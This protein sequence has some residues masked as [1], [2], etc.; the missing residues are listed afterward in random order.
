MKRVTQIYLFMVGR[1]CNFIE[2]LGDQTNDKWSE[3]NELLHC[4]ALF[5]ESYLSNRNK[6]A[7]N[8]T[9]N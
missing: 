3:F 7:Q 5:T 9:T 8:V 1:Y 6:M 2:P 4:Y